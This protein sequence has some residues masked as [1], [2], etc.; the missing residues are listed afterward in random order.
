M[1]KQLW[2]IGGNQQSIRDLRLKRSSKSKYYSPSYANQYFRVWV[3]HPR[4]IV[5]VPLCDQMLETHHVQKQHLRP[6]RVAIYER[7]G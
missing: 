2:N 4:M 5:A 6:S 7:R 1:Y 3:G